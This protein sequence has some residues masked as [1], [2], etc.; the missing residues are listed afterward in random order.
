[1][2]PVPINDG[3]RS[4]IWH[5]LAFA[6]QPVVSLYAE[7]VQFIQT[8]DIWRAACV[9]LLGTLVF[10]GI[11]TL[12]MRHA[13]KSAL[14][15]SLFIF[16]FF[17]WG[18][19]VAHFIPSTHVF[20]KT[21]VF[22]AYAAVFCIT[23]SAFAL[24]KNT[25]VWTRFFHVVGGVLV[26]L[27]MLSL[28]VQ[29]F[30][31]SSLRHT[32]Q[33]SQDHAAWEEAAAAPFRNHDVYVL[34]L[35]G[36]PRADVLLHDYTYDNSAFLN[37]LRARG[38]HVAN[39]SYSNYDR[40]LWSL[41]SALNGGYIDDLL[42]IGDPQS[43]NLRPLVGLMRQNRVFDLFSRQG[44]SLYAY[45][46]G[47]ELADMRGS[48][49][50]FL[51]PGRWGNEFEELILQ[52]TPIP[53]LYQRF[54]GSDYLFDAHRKRVRFVCDHLKS[55]AGHDA[56][57]PRFVWAHMVIP[58]DPIVFGPAG[59]PRRIQDRFLWGD[60]PPAHFTWSEYV[61][62]YGDQLTY[63]NMLMLD[64]LDHILSDDA[65]DP[66]VVIVAD[67]GPH[68]L[69]HHRCASS[70]KILCAIRMP[71]GME[72]TPRDEVDLVNLFPF[73]INILATA[74]EDIPLNE[75]TIL[76]RTHWSRPYQPTICEP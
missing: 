59:E 28:L 55:L 29:G 33:A 44:Y 11:L 13:D 16:A 60:A 4:H 1:M 58:H 69:P 12:I 43:T 47:F 45:E 50:H 27:P 9:L 31:G 62:V 17:F 8:L 15:T 20:Q 63:L 54:A 34:L 46:T 74:D 72:W 36:Y 5:P 41:A 71:H 18:H 24:L 52:M 38:F 49:D 14:I 6:L 75:Q 32:A 57:S 22:I 51:S 37:E 68:N 67:H 30:T 48:V 40:T 65:P 70:F 3:A 2:K 42:E 21:P 23:A 7:N 76:Y 64:V 25:R 61:S 56:D 19:F 73:L 66:V 26:L 53:A 10:W 39:N 35:D